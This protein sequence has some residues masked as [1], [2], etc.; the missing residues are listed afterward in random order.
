MVSEKTNQ[1]FRIRTSISSEAI[2]F[3]GN[4]HFRGLQALMYSLSALSPA[5]LALAHPLC[6]QYSDHAWTPAILVQSGHLLL[7]RLRGW[8]TPSQTA[9]HCL[10]KHGQALG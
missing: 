10:P 4:S 1:C 9:G 5:H 2:Q 3:C 6:V 8:L 7:D